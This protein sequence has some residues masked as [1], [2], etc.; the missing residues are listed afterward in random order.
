M[1]G[2]IFK[3]NRNQSKKMKVINS[4]WMEKETNVLMKAE[5]QVSK[6][7]LMTKIWMRLT[8]MMPKKSSKTK[9]RCRMMSKIKSIKKE[10]KMRMGMIKKWVNNKV[11]KEMSLFFNSI[12]MTLRKNRS[13]VTK[14]S[15][16]L[17]I[18][19]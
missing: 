9:A 3:I 2:E 4:N 15:K 10:G 13:K 12:Q 7:M 18:L 17:K 11:K 16:N 5:I 6:S 19:P 1:G 8:G 14:K